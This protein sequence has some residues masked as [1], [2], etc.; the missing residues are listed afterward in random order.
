[1]YLQCAIACAASLRFSIIKARS[2]IVTTKIDSA[3][4][5]IAEKLSSS[6]SRRRMLAILGGAALAPLMPTH[7]LAG[8]IPEHSLSPEDDA[9][10]DD[11]E[12][13]ACLFFWEQA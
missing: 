6:L 1:M 10:L 5:I 3:M 13:R 8:A 12:K 9:F 4:P 2:R 7:L 11:L